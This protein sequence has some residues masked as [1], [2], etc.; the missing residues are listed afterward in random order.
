VRYLRFSEVSRFPQVRRDLAL[1][2]DEQVPFSV[3]RE[4]VT[5]AASGLLRGLRL[6]DV[7]RGTGVE[8]GRKSVALGLI[9]QEKD[10]TLVDEE[11]D[12]V[13]AAIRAELSASLNAR[14]RE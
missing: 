8:P 12:K 1:V 14:F 2:V 6:F 9:F 10:R 5:F 7:Y 4:R 13:V 3:I 11:T